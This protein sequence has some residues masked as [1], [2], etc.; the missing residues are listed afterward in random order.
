MG[1][2]SCTVMIGFLALHLATIL[3][4]LATSTPEWLKAEYNSTH[5]KNST[6]NITHPDITKG[7]W[8][9][10]YNDSCTKLNQTIQEGQ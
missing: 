5:G 6:D 8:K 2:L 1:K 7:L 10:C 9:I 3:L 4:I